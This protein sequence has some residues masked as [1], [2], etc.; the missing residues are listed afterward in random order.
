MI[1]RRLFIKQA[2]LAAGGFAFSD[3]ISPIDLIAADKNKFDFKISLAE[4]SLHK[5][6]FANKITNLDFPEIAKKE[7][8]IDAVEYVSQFFHDKAKDKTYLTQL[9]D[10]CDE[11]NVKSV[12]IMVDHEGHLADKDATVREKAVENHYKWIDAAKYLGCQGIRVNL[13]GEGTHEEW[14]KGSV[15]SLTKLTTY[16]TN[17][18]M[19]ILAEN[20]GGHSSNAS[21]MVKVMKEVAQPRCGTLVD[22]ANFCVR[23]EKG[24]LYES[25][26]VEHYDSYKGVEELLPYAKGMSAKTFDFDSQLNETTI[27]YKRM[28]T[29]VKASGYKGYI[30]VEY[31]GK[32]LTEEKG[33][34]ATTAMLE[35]LRKD[36]Q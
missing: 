36:L 4:W 2:A 25:P 30:S 10:R 28:L 33:I 8:Q 9:R 32:R 1:D 31:E 18:K 24:D 5:P 22:F 12:L 6:L 14:L 3:F 29:L 21:L 13:H 17:L 34:R 19:N 20:H 11:H 23:R 16:A 35:E 27:D 7:Y 26:C 15:E